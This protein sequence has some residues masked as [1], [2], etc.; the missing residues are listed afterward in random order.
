MA[1]M[2]DYGNKYIFGG[3]FIIHLISSVS[4]SRLDGRASFA[5]S[6]DL[7]LWPELRTIVPAGIC[8]IG[9]FECVKASCGICGKMRR[10]LEE[11]QLG[12]EKVSAKVMLMD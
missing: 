10:D 9:G 1:G 5:F 7:F 3:Y 2:I 4:S 12:Q 11:H 6:L 8:T